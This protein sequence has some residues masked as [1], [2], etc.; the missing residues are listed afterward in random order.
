MSKETP[1]MQQYLQI[2]KQYPDAFLFYRV[3]DFY[4]LFFDDAKEVAH[5]LELTLTSRNKSDRDS[6]PMCGVPHRAVEGYIEQLV[7]MGHKVVVCDQVEDP[8]LAKGMVKREVTRVVTPGTQVSHQKDNNYLVYLNE[9]SAGIVLSYTDLMTGEIQVTICENEDDVVN[10]CSQL[11]TKEIVYSTPLSDT[12]MNKLKQRLTLTFSYQEKQ[13][14][15]YL[16]LVSDLS[17]QE[18]KEA[19]LYLVSY[20]KQT[21]KLSLSH[22]KKAMHYESCH[23]LKMDYYSK[24]NLEL[25]RSIRTQKKQ[26]TL[27]H[28][29]DQTKTAMGSRLL[30]QWLDRPL[31]QQ[32]SIEQRLNCVA[33]F[34][35]PMNHLSHLT[36][37]DCLTHVYDLERLVGKVAMGTVNARELLQ[38]AMSLEQLPPLVAE[39]EAMDSQLWHD[40]ITHL[41]DLHHLV[42]MIKTAINPDAPLSLTEGNIINQGYDETL[43][44]YIETMTNAHQWLAQLEAHEKEVTGIKNLHVKYNKVHG[45]FIEVSKI[46]SKSID[47]TRYERKQ[48]LAN[49]ERFVT[50]EL[51]Q[52]ETMILEAEEKRYERE[53]T[54]FVEIRDAVKKESHALQQM[55]TAIAT[56]DVLQGFAI[57]S[58]QKNYVRP[59]FNTKNQL[60]IIDGRHPVVEEVLG[61]EEYVPNSITMDEGTN[62]LLITGPNMSGKSTY[63]RQL[64][65]IVIMAQMGCYIPAKEAT[66]PIFDQIFTR[67][68]ASDDL[69]SGQSTFMVE[70]MEANY[71]LQHAT[72][73]SLLLFDE[74]GRGTA[75][76]DGMALA[77]A[78]IEYLQQYIP[79][80]TLFSTHYHEL[81]TL[82][83]TWPSMRNIHVGAK[84]EGNELIF[85]HKMFDGPCDQSFGIQVAR[86]AH[87]PEEL[88]Q[89][90]TAI[91]NELE[92]NDYHHDVHEVIKEVPVIKEVIKEVPVVQE[93]ADDTHNEQLS[94][95]GT[96]HQHVIDTLRKVDVMNTTPFE[97]LQLLAQL[98]KEINQ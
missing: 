36:I 37:R 18:E 54:L 69:V 2:K 74:L 33:S 77:Q 84:E 9:A 71:A 12:L 38:L 92:N 94:L 17:K 67:I 86:H 52:L 82:E 48:T 28:I 62:L 6:A 81:T 75:T 34:L 80:K 47:T 63:M 73:H 46:A 41:Y 60:S 44:Q 21:Q 90:A 91:L 78:I 53:Y 70:M 22:L 61:Q 5:L 79:A 3:G 56:V 23:Y 58:Q 97:A 59:T 95:F 19:V 96:D 7:D 14:D 50:N 65:L 20:L 68:G 42:V 55:A 85:L 72:S 30:K 15:T 13:D 43:D 98:Q 66:L 87:L 25:T 57:L 11:Q 51:K 26:G 29:M 31:I 49:N 35:E 10:E 24:Y 88:L 16:D 45:Y 76:Y 40:V 27:L 83:E 39:L 1:M 4:E 32:Q 64:A 93:G 8:K 89:R